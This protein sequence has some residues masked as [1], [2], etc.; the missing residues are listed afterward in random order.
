M[1]KIKKDGRRNNKGRSYNS[2]EI[3]GKELKNDIKEH[4]KNLENCAKKIYLSR[5]QLG[6]SLNNNK[7]TKEILIDICKLIDI[8]PNYYYKNSCGLVWIFNFEDHSIKREK[9]SYK[10]YEILKENQTIIDLQKEAL[11][12]LLLALNYE[13]DDINKILFYDHE[14]NNVFE[15]INKII[16]NHLNELNILHSDKPTKTKLTIIKENTL[17]K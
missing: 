12:K 13:N 9:P 1:K 17:N 14:F 4:F 10:Y 2:I 7:I 6:K 8:A 16:N 11:N 15:K 5:E 3:D